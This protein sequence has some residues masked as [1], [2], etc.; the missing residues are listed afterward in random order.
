MLEKE[1]DLTVALLTKK[2]ESWP[3]FSSYILHV[4]VA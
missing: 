1:I 4:D 2:G 3:V